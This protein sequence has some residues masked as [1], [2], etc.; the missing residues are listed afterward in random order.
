MNDVGSPASQYG[1]YDSPTHV[2]Q[3]Y[4]THY[5]TTIRAGLLLRHI[6]GGNARHEILQDLTERLVLLIDCAVACTLERVQSCGV[7]MSGKI[8]ALVRRRPNIVSTN[9][10]QCW[11]CDIP[12]PCSRIKFQHRRH[13]YLDGVGW[14]GS[15]RVAAAATT[16]QG[17]YH[18]WM[19]WIF[20]RGAPKHPRQKRVGE[21]RWRQGL[22][23]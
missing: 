19:G 17:G 4:K 10:H 18:G 14:S 11:L 23:K 9:C 2:T 5:T 22:R 20:Q 3:A 8:F 13:L 12:E 7:D 21:I 1:A 16:A 15:R 6:I